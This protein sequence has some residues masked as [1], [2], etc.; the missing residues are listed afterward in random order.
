MSSQLNSDKDLHHDNKVLKQL[1]TER[2]LH[3]DNLQ[4]HIDTQETLQTEYKKEL[5]MEHEF[6]SPKF[7]NEDS[8]IV[9]ENFERM[10]LQNIN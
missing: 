1:S 6:K 8:K 9:N 5:M 2:Y 10:K 3:D 4:F 7:F